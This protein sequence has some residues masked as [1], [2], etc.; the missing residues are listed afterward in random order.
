MEYKYWNQLDY[1]NIPYS[2]ETVASSGCGLCSACMV[3]ENMTGMTFTPAEAV[4]LSLA[5]GAYDETG[6]EITLLAPAVCEK[7]G[8]TA[9]YTCDHG[10]MQQ[11]LHNGEGMAIAN[12]GGDRPGWTGVFSDVGHFIVLVS[13]KGRE[14]CA[15][16]PAMVEGRYESEGRRG[17]VRVEGNLAYVDIAVLAKECENRYPSYVLFRKK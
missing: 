9:E 1:P 15:M 4:E 16:D 7:F 5:N 2:D 6:T 17:K 3:V 11:F 10:K 14:V 13:A 8:L 12:V